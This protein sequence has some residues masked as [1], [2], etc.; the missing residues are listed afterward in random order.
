ML[1]FG[2]MVDKNYFCFQNRWCRSRARERKGKKKLEGNWIYKDSASTDYAADNS[3]DHSSSTHSPQHK[4]F[5]SEATAG[6]LSYIVLIR[7][8]SVAKGGFFHWETNK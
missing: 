8:L 1:L 4:I 6:Q 5:T 2:K 3:S 7:L